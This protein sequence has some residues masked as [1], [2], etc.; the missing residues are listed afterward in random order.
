MNKKLFIILVSLFLVFSISSVNA[1]EKITASPG[2]IFAVYGPDTPAGQSY[3]YAI[4][5]DSTVYYFDDSI[6]SKLASYSPKFAEVFSQ[7]NNNQIA[8]T[9]EF[10]NDKSFEF[11]YISGQQVGMN[12]D[13]HVITEI[14]LS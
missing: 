3:S 9:S 6:A 12:K 14:Y 2:D 8:G 13:A 1:S 5:V 4:E 10:N 11:E 7:V